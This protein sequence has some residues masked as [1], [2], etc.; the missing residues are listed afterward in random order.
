[1]T[2]DRCYGQLPSCG[3]VVALL[4]GVD[5]YS[6]PHCQPCL[7]VHLDAAD[8]GLRQEPLNLWRINEGSPDA[9]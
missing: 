2:V 3:P 4:R 6:R 9:V 1:M 8:A 7:D 5:G